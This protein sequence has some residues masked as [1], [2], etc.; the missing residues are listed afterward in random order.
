MT[1][2]YKLK[3]VQIHAKSTRN[4]RA[5]NKNASVSGLFENLLLF[6]EILQALYAIGGNKSEVKLSYKVIS[7]PNL[8]S[9]ILV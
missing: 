6:I 7:R 2:L 4:E 9:S 5:T 8:F 3:S 1:R